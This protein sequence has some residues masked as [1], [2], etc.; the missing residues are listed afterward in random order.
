MRAANG[1]AGPPLSHHHREIQASILE[2]HRRPRSYVTVIVVSSR[3]R[4]HAY[5]NKPRALARTSLA[6]VCVL[7]NLST[8]HFVNF[9]RQ[10]DVTSRRKTL[11]LLLSLS[12]RSQIPEAP[13]SS[14]NHIRARSRI[15]RRDASFRDQLISYQSRVALTSR[16]QCS[17]RVWNLA[18]ASV[19]A[20]VS[21]RTSFRNGNERNFTEIGAFF[22]IG[23]S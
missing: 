16:E 11:S 15:R 22:I 6:Y 1:L 4:K 7:S 10:F 5:H 12:R 2:V 19:G 20:D 8:D 14:V 9:S 3:V 21:R 17:T 13:R 23:F 18:T